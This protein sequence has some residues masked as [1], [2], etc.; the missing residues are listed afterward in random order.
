M[1]L[2]HVVVNCEPDASGIRQIDIDSLDLL[3]D[4]VIEEDEEDEWQEECDEEH[5]SHI[6]L[7]RLVTPVNA[8]N[9]KSQYIRFMTML[10]N[11]NK[12]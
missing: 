6:G 11:Y 1:Y 2:C 10:N 5:R 9:T 4:A 3:R 12:G 8:T 7:V